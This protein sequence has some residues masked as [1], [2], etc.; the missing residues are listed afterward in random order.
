MYLY[1]ICTY[2]KVHVFI[3]VYINSTDQYINSTDQY[4]NSILLVI[5]LL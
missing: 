4:I 5:L 2:I 3:H 1:T